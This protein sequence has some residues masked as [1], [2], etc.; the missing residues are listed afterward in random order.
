MFK[1]EFKPEVE[2]N[3]AVPHEEDKKVIKEFRKLLQ[4]A[5]D[6]G[7]QNFESQW[8]QNSVL[9]S[10]NDTFDYTDKLKGK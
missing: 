9:Y 4:K 5:Y 8:G 7:Y 6:Y 3:E 1:E 2:T 10:M